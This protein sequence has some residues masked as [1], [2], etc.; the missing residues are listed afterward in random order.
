MYP[1]NYPENATHFGD[2]LCYVRYELKRLHE[3]NWR[4]YLASMTFIA[5]DRPL[6]KSKKELQSWKIR[7]SLKTFTLINA[8]IKECL[9]QTEVKQEVD[10]F[11]WQNI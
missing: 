2:S 6:K 1:R 9:S 3:S 4:T 10:Y 11:N 8:Q 7:D 5:V